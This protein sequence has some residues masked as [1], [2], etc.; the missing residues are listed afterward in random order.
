MWEK[1]WTYLSLP[2]P[3]DGW[4][5]QL[6]SVLIRNNQDLQCLMLEEKKIKG[7]PHPNMG[8]VA[9]TEGLTCDLIM[10][11]VPLK[12][13]YRMHE[14]KPSGM[15]KKTQITPSAFSTASGNK[16]E[17]MI[18]VPWVGTKQCHAYP[19]SSNSRSGNIFSIYHGH[20]VIFVICLISHFPQVLYA[21]N[22]SQKGKQQQSQGSNN[23]FH[24]LE[25]PSFITRNVQIIYDN[26]N[27]DR[28]AIH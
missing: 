13:S 4:E 1:Q 17:E 18:S 28:T 19:L 10:C 16:T 22:M 3:S 27:I 2:T 7:S 6:S 8:L 26:S 5:D 20:L 15:T 11:R 25:E 9:A 23:T 14:T 24:S 21:Q 12:L